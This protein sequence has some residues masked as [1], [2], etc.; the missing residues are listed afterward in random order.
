MKRVLAAVTFLCATAAPALSATLNVTVRNAAGLPVAGAPVIAAAFTGQ[1]SGPDPVQSVTG[2]TDASGVA[3]LAG[4]TDNLGY[5]VFASSQGFLPSLNDQFN[6]PGHAHVQGTGALTAVT[7]TI[8]STSASNLG[9]IDVDVQGASNNSLVF[10]AVAPQGSMEPVAVGWTTTDAAGKAGS[11]PGSAQPPIRL[12]NV[13]YTS[14]YFVQGQNL[15]AKTFYGFPGTVAL[16]AGTPLI[17][18]TSGGP[19]PLLNSLL[20][21]ANAIAAVQT[22]SA[23]GGTGGGVSVQGT[24]I[25]AATKAPLPSVQM[26]FLYCTTDAA[27]IQNHNNSCWTNVWTSADQNGFFSFS[28]LQTHTTYYGQINGTC[29]GSTCYRGYQSVNYN[30]PVQNTAPGVNDFL[31]DGA[32]ILKQVRLTQAAGGPGHMAVYVT[33]SNGHALPQAFVNVYPDWSSCGA[34]P[35][36]PGYSQFNGQATTGYVLV[37]GLFPGRY[38]LNVGTPF[39][40]QNLQFNAGTDGSFG[41]DSDDLALAVDTTSTANDIYITKANGGGSAGYSNPLSSVTVVVAVSTSTSGLVSG[42]VTF[43]QAVDLSN[44]PITIALQPQNCNNNCSG[45]GFTVITNAVGS[46]TGPAVSYAVHVSSG[47][48]YWINLNANYWGL[49]HSNG[50][51]QVTADLTRVSSIGVNMKMAPA[52]RVIGKLYNPDGA[53]F[54]PTQGSGNGPG[55]NASINV[56]GQNSWGWG[57]VNNDGS[58]AIGGVLP[59]PGTLSVNGYGGYKYTNKLPLPAVTVV[60]GQDAYADVHTVN[61]LGVKLHV[62]T[63]TLGAIPPEVCVGGNDQCPAENWMV[64]A[65]QHGVAPTHDDILAMMDVTDDHADLFGFRAST[66]VNARGCNGPSAPGFCVNSMAAPDQY[67]FRL[68]RVGGFDNRAFASPATRPYFVVLNSTSN[69][70]VDS[71]HVGTPEFVREQDST[72]TVVDVNLTPASS[73]V[74]VAT[75]VFVGTVTAQNMITLHDF[76]NFGGSFSK[77]LQY[78]PLVSLYDS[79]GTLMAAGLVVPF[80]PA[81]TPFDNQ[82]NAAVAQGDSAAFF[83][84]IT[85][86]GWG[87]LGYDIRGIPAGVYTAVV[88]TP[89]YPPYT[90]KVTLGAGTNRLDVNLDQLV[91]QGATLSGAVTDKNTSAAIANAVVTISASNYPAQ[92][93]TTDSSGQY[94]R[95]GLPPGSFTL[96]VTG[97]SGYA[98]AQALV[99]VTASASVTKNFPL[100]PAGGTIFGT[101]SEASVTSTKLVGAK[102]LAYDET[103]SQANPSALQTLYSVQTDTS[104]A[105]RLAS[106]ITGDTY[107]VSVKAERVLSDGSLV[108]YY[109]TNQSTTAAAGAGNDLDFALSKKPLDISVIGH[110]VAGAFEFQILNPGNF[111]TGDAWVGDT[112]FSKTASTEVGGSGSAWG[113]FQ[114]LKDSQNRLYLQLDFLDGGLSAASSHVL[115]IEAINHDYVTG[116]DATYVKELTFSAS[117]AATSQSADQ[118]LLGDTGS[119]DLFSGLTQNAIPISQDA[120]QNPSYLS[121]PPASVLPQVSTAIPTLSF[122]AADSLSAPAFVSSVR[123]GALSAGAIS[124][125]VYTLSLS[126]VQYV[127]GGPGVDLTLAYNKQDVNTADLAMY[128][129]NATTNQ[130]EIVPGLQTIDPTKGTVKANVKSFTSLAGFRSGSP[131]AVAVSAGAYRPAASGAVDS[132]SFAILH[133]SSVGSSSYAGT[134]LRAFNF[135]N[136]FN[137]DSKTVSVVNGG[138][139]TA[140]PTNGTVIKYEVPAGMGG[141]VVIRVYTLAGELVREIDGGNVSGGTYNYVVWDG[142]NRNGGKVANGVYYGIVSVPGG[143]A[144]DGTFKMAVI[145]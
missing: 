68:I 94:T 142:R 14:S 58:F 95:S 1:Y 11:G 101:V 34:A 46:S 7:I 18:Y 8:S 73:Q 44:D 75:A 64:K 70:L 85:V 107:F 27:Y 108:Q 118:A 20:N 131:L 59:G 111:Q 57:P 129:H 140:L 50:G 77:F 2:V 25:D 43:P 28:G 145:K 136:P 37:P 55:I 141:H 105:Y 21:F 99:S 29:S 69:V 33:D 123:T 116:L 51:G 134:T 133:P 17:H 104:G 132:G 93:V 110:P 30:S 137:L 135:P 54:V 13:P 96:S 80:P 115:H 12:L 3:S 112:P 65:F 41:C 102:V 143:T 76:Q 53:L 74:N 98:P 138:A 15:A 120:S 40:N 5:D 23:Q 62:T 127:S 121:C 106:L 90:T 72:M 67:D 92:T 78:L 119:S 114:E 126:S 9:E 117:G 122:T 38:N 81:E 19:N 39:S 52:G 103:A 60:A 139:T 71:S 63:T 24:V 88:T 89:N 4:L 49:V 82:L 42:T 56:R 16:S 79:S 6:N 36:S 10:A 87:P 31:Y 109:V 32:Q 48:S 47:Q 83:N 100:T 22:Q 86:S 113:S 144:K 84:L 128:H 26:N 45:G 35:P 61:A 97:V 130:W 66:G 91:G 124:G 125:Q